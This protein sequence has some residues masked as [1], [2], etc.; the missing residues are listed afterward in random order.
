MLFLL[1]TNAVSDLMRQQPLITA[2]LR[3]LTGQDKVIT[4]TIVKG[5]ILHGMQK[6][7]LGKRRTEIE[8]QLAALM[9]VVPCWSIP[10]NAADHYANLKIAC[11]AG[12][13]AFSENDLWVAS[14]CLAYTAVSITRDQD[15]S[16]LPG[17]SVQDWTV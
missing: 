8:T 1:D 10:E 4:C 12:G 16:R 7:G 5:E 14:T 9:P 11:H 13:I 3:S 6:L 2:K 17:V 15:F